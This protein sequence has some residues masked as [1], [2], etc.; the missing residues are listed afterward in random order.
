MDSRVSLFESRVAVRFLSNHRA[1]FTSSFAAA[2]ASI[3]VPLKTE[4]YYD[5]C[6]S[7]GFLSAVGFSLYWPSLRSKFI[8]GTAGATIPAITA[9][10]PRQLV[11]SGITALWAGRLGTF[12]FQRIQKHGG[13]SRFD[14]IKPSPIK[15]FGAWMMQA[16]WIAITA[17]P[18][19]LVNTTPRTIQPKFGP[20][21]FLGLSV[22]VLGWGL[23]VVADR[24][25]TLWR[26]GKSQGKHDEQFI[27]SGVWAWSRR[28]YGTRAGCVSGELPV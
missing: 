1:L 9:F 21:D 25:K 28:E 24:Q 22:W 2:C 15:F 5:L 20:L 3:A 6:G 4:K 14:D 26:E 12:L 23:E 16:T 7:M 11:M 8:L 13:D 17:L 27:G 19:W 18:V 10:H